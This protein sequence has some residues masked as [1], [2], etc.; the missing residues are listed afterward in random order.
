MRPRTHT[1]TAAVTPESKQ[2]GEVELA[3]VYGFRE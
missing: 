3:Y 1:H 2:T